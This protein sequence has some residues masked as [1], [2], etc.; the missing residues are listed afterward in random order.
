MA[1][2][3]D[4]SAQGTSTA[5]RQV[6]GHLRALIEAGE[7]APGDKVP[8]ERA[9]AVEHDV[10]RNTA[11]EAIR[12]LA[13]SGLVTP[14]HGRGVY[15]RSKPRLMRFGQQRYSRKLRQET[16]VSPYHAEVSAQGRLP[17]A[18]C[19]SIERVIPPPEIIERLDV[20][21][22]S[23]SVVRRENWYYADSEPMQLGIT[24]IPWSIAEGSPLG[25]TDD[26]GK[27]DLYGR[28]EDV[29]HLIT[30]TREE[31]TAR[32]PTPDEA[33]QLQ[34]PDGVPVL[35]VL[36]TGIDQDRRPF[37]VTRFVMR[38]DYTGLDYSM[39][40]EEG[41]M[42]EHS[43][44]TVRPRHP[45]DLQE[46]GQVL[47]RVHELD[48]YPVEGVADPESWLTPARELASWTALLDHQVI[49][50]IS[51][52]E[53]DQ[54]D[55]AAQLWVSTTD[56]QYDDVA[57]PVRLFVDPPY[58]TDG[59]GKQLMLAAYKHAEQHGK[60]LVFDVMLKDEKAIR[61]YESLGC[62]RLGT[63]THHY[64]EGLQEPAAVY[65]APEMKTSRATPTT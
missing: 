34:V 63:I 46:L 43:S 27:G 57:V 48:G 56:G 65:V 41:Q 1:M 45:D 11:R 32:M 2:S 33:E 10:A 64:G 14:H 19:T 50:Q 58:R 17:S 18:V 35:D 9:L 40:V 47:V 51:L 55:D 22:D 61:L 60:R 52:V 37:E 6:A 21:A 23:A 53:A 20:D 16:G 49:G 5:S 7:L 26:L 15:V 38:A 12:Q 13:E 24:F 25:Y 59:A 29:G 8:S 54:Q 30:Y 4:R 62:E 42:S 28:F 36:H 39:P 44:L 31:A 3:T